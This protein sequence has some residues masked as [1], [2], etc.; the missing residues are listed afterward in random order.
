MKNI[1]LD[2]VKEMD[3]S[4]T[5]KRLTGGYVCKIMKVTDIPEREL[6]KIEYTV[7]EGDDKEFKYTWGYPEF[8]K[9]YKEGVAQSYFKG[10]ITAVEESN[11][12]YKFAFNEQSLLGKLVGLVIGQ[13]EYINNNGDIKVHDNVKQTLSIRKIREND[14]KVP[15]LKKVPVPQQS[16]PNPFQTE[17][18]TP[19]STVEDTDEI[20]F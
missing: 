3:G 6:L 1:N 17:T 20:P 2:N 4:N 13:E 18:T 19:T 5:F 11:P 8:S 10:F 12:N 15:E 14:Y 16:E 7:A 9:S